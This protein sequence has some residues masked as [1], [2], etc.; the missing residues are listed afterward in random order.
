MIVK[1]KNSTYEVI[2]EEGFLCD[3]RVGAGPVPRSVKKISWFFEGRRDFLIQTVS[4]TKGTEISAAEYLAKST[5]PA[6]EFVFDGKI[7]GRQFAKQ[8][9]IGSSAFMIEA[10]PLAV[11]ETVP[12]ETDPV[13]AAPRLKYVFGTAYTGGISTTHGQGVDS[14]GVI[15][16]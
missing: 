2:I 7:A 13:F 14:G 12:G 5:P 1:T 3:Q 6:V 15:D 9:H 16:G 10:T 11:K 4:P 8:Y